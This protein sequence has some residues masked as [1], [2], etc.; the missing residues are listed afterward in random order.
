MAKSG[1]KAASLSS[2]L[3]PIMGS[4]QTTPMKNLQDFEVL[5]DQLFSFLVD[6]YGYSPCPAHKGGIFDSAFVRSY[7]RDGMEVSICFGDADSHHLC[8]IVFKDRREE[9][10]TDDRPQLRPFNHL[11]DLESPSFDDLTRADISENLGYEDVLARYAG[12]LHEFGSDA[13]NGDFSRFFA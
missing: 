1:T 13:L 5:T 12:L 7:A 3:C 9:K 10:S 8:Q 6:D 11:L 4:K 2:L